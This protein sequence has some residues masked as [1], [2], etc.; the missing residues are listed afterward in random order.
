MNHFRYLSAIALIGVFSMF[1]TAMADTVGPSGAPLYVTRSDC[2][3]LVSHVP[4][5]AN[6]TPGTDVHGKYVPP[7]D[8]PSSGPAMPLPDKISFNLQINPMNYAQ[9]NSAQQSIATNSK[10]IVTNSQALQAAQA[11]QPQLQA[12]V[13]SLQ[14]SLTTVT[15]QK[16]QIDSQVATKTA[17]IIAATGGTSANALQLSE[18]QRELAALAQTTTGSAAYQTLVSQQAST[19]QALAAATQAASA[20]QQTITQD[21]AATPQLQNQLTAAQGQLAGT[22]GRFDNTAM[23]VGK[24]DV[25][26]KTGQVSFNGQP[27]G[28]SDQNIIAEACRKAGFR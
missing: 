24:V 1:S 25:D 9:R 26:L 13:T 21:T 16:A 19:T 23:P 5:G 4:V 7:A 15:A 14:S 20:N 3:A 11:A 27:L 18:R 8:L 6:Y 28:G 2:A 10:A 17:A 12:K 22:Q